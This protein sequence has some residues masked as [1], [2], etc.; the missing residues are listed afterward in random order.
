MPT[1]IA[2][3]VEKTNKE[4]CALSIHATDQGPKI[5][6]GWIRLVPPFQLIVLCP[7]EKPP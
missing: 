5:Q 2:K 4:L 1:S 7:Y 3:L 6:F